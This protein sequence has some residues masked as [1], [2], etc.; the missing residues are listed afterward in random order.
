[1]PLGKFG[2]GRRIRT[3]T[4][5]FGDRCATINTIPLNEVLNYISIYL[6]YMQEK[7]KFLLIL[8]TLFATQYVIKHSKVNVGLTSSATRKL[9]TLF[10]F[11]T[12]LLYKNIFFLL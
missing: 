12:R 7:N 1:M 2:R 10:I 5:G 4:G 11:R 6:I 8:M 9:S 3:L